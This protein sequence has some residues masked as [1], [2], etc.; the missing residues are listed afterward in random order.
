MKGMIEQAEPAFD[1]ARSL[2]PDSPAPPVALAMAWMQSGRTDRAVELLRT[3]AAGART[4]VVPYMF[5]IALIRSGVDP[6]DAGGLEAV[7]ALQHA[8]RL[9]PALAGARGELGKIL[10]KRGDVEGAI[11]ELE[12]A[13][14]LDPDNVPVAYSLAQAYRRVG[15]IDRAQEL[16]ARVSTLNAEERGDMPDRELQRIM[17]RI[18][19]DGSAPGR[20]GPG[21]P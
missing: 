18:V 21:N 8:V 1:R 11:A 12:L 13:A 2:M 9:D 20:N 19:R 6:A 14:R 15:K 4:A 16:L 17:V 5:A 7:E 3:H 10:L